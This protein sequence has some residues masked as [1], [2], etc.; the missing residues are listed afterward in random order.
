MSWVG[1][2]IPGMQAMG[3]GLQSAVGD[4]EE[5]RKTL[6]DTVDKL[7]DDA[8]WSGQGAEKFRKGW[9]LASMRVGF[10]K[11]VGDKFGQTVQD[12]GD[13]L[14]KV[15]ADLSNTADQDGRKGAQIDQTTGAPLQLVITGDPNTQKAKDALA[16]QQD[17]NQFYADAMHTADG[18]RLTAAT[19]LEGIATSLAPSDDGN[20]PHWDSATTMADYLK[21]LY[22]IPNAKNR[23]L[24]AKL[25]DEITNLRN[26][27]KDAR[28]DLKAAKAAYADAGR[29][30]PKDDPARINHT[31]AY[32]DLKDV[33]SQLADA[34]AG[35]G[36]KP[37]MEVLNT[38]I[39][40]LAKVFPAIDGLPKGLKFLKEVPVVDIA[41]ASLV[42]AFQSVDDTQKGWSPQTAVTLDGGSQALGLAAAAAVVLAAPVEAPVAAV[43]AGA[44]LVAWTVGDLGSA[45]VHE[46]WSEDVHNNGVVVGIADGAG[47]SLVNGGKA[48][49]DDVKSTGSTVWHGITSLF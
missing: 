34:E 20:E 46:H 1:G 47:H 9:T 6:G 17:Y 38:N 44:G 48:V 16:A 2:D 5:I 31:A 24:A 25:P 7:A 36:E 49:W 26:E 8:N 11:G 30:L 35:K 39:G 33:E 42:T 29:A 43:A 22:V 10:I 12:L 21:G 37:F 32:N 18:L 13:K 27:F 40:D 3:A 19:A 23:D 41:A 15:E 28:K 45:A 14:A 4:L